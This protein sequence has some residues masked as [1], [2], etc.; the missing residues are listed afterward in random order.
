MSNNLEDKLKIDPSYEKERIINFIKD[1]LKKL[2][3]DGAVIGLSGGL[4]SSACAYLLTEALGKDKVLGLI[5]PERDSATINMEHARMVAKNLDIKTIEIDISEILEKM[6]VYKV[7]PKELKTKADIEDFRRL[8]KK[9]NKTLGDYPIFKR[10]AAGYGIEKLP[11]LLRPFSKRLHK[12]SAF[13]FTKIR[14]RMLYLYFYAYQHNYA[15]IGTLDKSEFSVGLF[16]VHGDG[17]CDLAILRHLYKSQI[18]EL[19]VGIGVPQ[20]ITQKQSSGDVYGNT[21]WEESLGMTYKQLDQILLGLE[22]GHDRDQLA[23]IVSKEALECVEKGL[24]V[25][26]VVRKMPLD[27]SVLKQAP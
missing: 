20:E 25:S 4:D 27:I 10:L 17:A 16:D 13:I 5:L 6:G 19:A 9:V 8:H 22:Q 23:E 3:K 26:K 15:L 18:K 12:T 1:G 14:T 24:E 11:I 7:G 2:N 21:P